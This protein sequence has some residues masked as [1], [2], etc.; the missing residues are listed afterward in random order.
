VVISGENCI[1]TYTSKKKLRQERQ[2]LFCYIFIETIDNVL[3][4]FVKT[5]Q[6]LH[7]NT[8]APTGLQLLL[9]QIALESSRSCLA[10]LWSDAKVF[11]NT[12][13]NTF[14]KESKIL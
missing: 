1:A 11:Q 12:R 10:H 4:E 14:L 13:N 3:R 9:K 7:H 6:T 8:S 2:L 5:C